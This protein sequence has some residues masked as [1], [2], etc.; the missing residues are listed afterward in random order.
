MAFIYVILIFQA[1]LG[2]QKSLPYLNGDI[3]RK[4]SAGNSAECKRPAHFCFIDV[5]KAFDKSEFKRVLDILERNNVPNDV[6][7][8]IN[9]HT[10]AF[11]GLVVSVL[12]TGPTGYSVAGSSPTEGGGCLWV[13]EIPS[14]HFLRSHVVDLRHVKEPYTA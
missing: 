14:T 5:K 4:I 3:Y 9:I 7:I 11:G 13:I 12:A 2:G 6:V 10:F 1:V 8:L